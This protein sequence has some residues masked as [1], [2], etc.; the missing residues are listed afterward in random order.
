MARILFPL[1]N[2]DKMNSK[3]S[4][5]FGHAPFFG[6]YDEDDTSLFIVKNE[7]NH[8]DVLKSAIYQIKEIFNPD[9]I[10]VISIGQKAI[11]EANKLSVSLKTGNYKILS[12]VI[13]NLNKLDLKV[14]S[15]GNTH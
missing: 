5:H 3:L 8:N 14:G 11:N 13:D 2:D 12:E 7:L 9:V 4:E 6:I 1:L 15:C 10:F